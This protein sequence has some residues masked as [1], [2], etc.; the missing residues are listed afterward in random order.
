MKKLNMVK[1]SNIEESLKSEINLTRKNGSWIAW[2]HGKS[3]AKDIDLKNIQTKMD[4]FIKD[5]IKDLN[6]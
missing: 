2:Y 4:K 1:S 5:M 3:I 6:K